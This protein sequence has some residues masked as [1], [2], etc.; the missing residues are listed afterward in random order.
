[1]ASSMSNG[2]K[3][4]LAVANSQQVVATKHTPPD[5]TQVGKAKSHPRVALQHKKMAV[6]ARLSNLDE[7]P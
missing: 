4:T 2:Q 6:P 1:M 3:D 5:K 7:T